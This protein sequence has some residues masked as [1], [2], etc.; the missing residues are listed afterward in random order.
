M[1]TSAHIEHMYGICTFMLHSREVLEVS[2]AWE[3]PNWISNTSRHIFNV[4]RGF[5]WVNTTHHKRLIYLSVNF[6]CQLPTS[7]A[8]FLFNYKFYTNLWSRGVLAPR[9]K[10]VTKSF[11]NKTFI[12]PMKRLFSSLGF[13]FWFYAS[14]KV[15]L[16]YIYKLK[17]CAQKPLC[18]YFRAWGS[19][20]CF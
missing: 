20:R 18:F 6:V 4:I 13:P 1:R 5:Y 8:D 2:I 12:Q 7:H 17:W 15:E 10:M 9:L 16:W 14:A 19:Q 11:K 3:T